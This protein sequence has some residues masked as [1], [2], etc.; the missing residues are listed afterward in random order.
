MV[1]LVL[2]AIDPI[3]TDMLE[4]GDPNIE[5]KR[6]GDVKINKCKHKTSYH[7][8]LYCETFPFQ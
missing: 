1:F 3:T 7:Q 4:Q 2:E 6:E 8:F 5:A